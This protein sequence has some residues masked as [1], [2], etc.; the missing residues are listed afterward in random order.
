MEGFKKSIYAGTIEELKGDIEEGGL[1]AAAHRI[2][3]EAKIT[4][5]YTLEQESQPDFE[6]SR[7]K[8]N[9]EA[10]L[11]IANHPGYYDTFLILNALK[12]KDVKIVVSAENYE[13]FAPSIGEDLLIKATN[14][15]SEAFAFI[16][17]I[18]SH[19]ESG[20]VVLIY[21]TGGVDR[22]NKENKDFTFE[23][24]FSVILKRC[25]KPNDMVYSFHIDENDIKP[26]VDEKIS[27]MPGVISAISLHPS[28]N[29]NKLKDEA[30][31]KVDERYSTA[32]EWQKVLED[33][34]KE[35][36]N[37]MLSKHFTES[38]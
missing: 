11:I 20:G 21:P 14:E 30:V 10:G 31:V 19:I 24:G 33:A 3:E 34:D 35:T 28:L 7:N 18:K 9:T 22:V 27:R 38:F 13:S 36:K 2:L 32:E 12:R 26:L 1:E 15:P 5:A 29:V 17:S 4:P 6:E 8:L 37:E 25:L 23:N 16:R